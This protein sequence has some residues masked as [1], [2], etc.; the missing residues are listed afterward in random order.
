[1]LDVMRSETGMILIQEKQIDSPKTKTVKK[2]NQNIFK[3]RHI[4]PT[5]FFHQ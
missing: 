4:A 3:L 5:S 1:M 2:K